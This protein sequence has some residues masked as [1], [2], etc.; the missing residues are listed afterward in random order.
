MQIE[1]ASEDAK[2]DED[3]KGEKDGEEKMVAVG[4]EGINNL[5]WVRW[6]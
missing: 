3:V 5:E 4:P 2:M 1:K 6:R